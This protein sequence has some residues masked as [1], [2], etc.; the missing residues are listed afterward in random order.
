M[1]A[2]PITANPRGV[3]IVY[4]A[5]IIIL[6]N[7]LAAAVLMEVRWRNANCELRIA[8]CE[9]RIANAIANADSPG[10]MLM[11]VTGV[12][13]P[14]FRWR[15]RHNWLHVLRFFGSDQFTEIFSAPAQGRNL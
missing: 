2:L 15:H 12:H 6:D 11:H 5:G 4:F 9:L 7:L 10:L 8:N 13:V 1:G 14:S 3:G